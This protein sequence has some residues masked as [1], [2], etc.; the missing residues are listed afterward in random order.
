MSDS[1]LCLISNYPPRSIDFIF[2][3]QAGLGDIAG[4]V[5]GHHY[6]VNISIQQV[7][8][9]VLFPSAYKGDVYTIL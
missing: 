2:G 9:F 3:T 1:F 8:H 7:T 5:P 6:K 4:L